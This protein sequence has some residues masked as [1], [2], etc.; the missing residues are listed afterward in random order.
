MGRKVATLVLVVLCWTM[1]TAQVTYLNRPDLLD[2]VESCLQN[3]Y[4][5]SFQKARLIQ[6]ELARETPNHPMPY[7]LEA[8]IVYWENFPLS[9]EDQASEKFV[10]QMNRT[11]E[12]AERYIEGDKT[13]LEGVFFDLYGRAFKAMFWADNGRAGKVIPD[14]RS[15]FRDTKEGFELKEKFNEFYFSTGLYNY[16][17]EAYPEAHPVYKP[18]LAFMQKG[19]KKLGLQQLNYAINH[20][21]FLKVE[22][23]LFMSIIQLKYEKDLNSAAIFAERL[24]R[25][26][27]KN[28]FYHGHLVTILLHQ[29]RYQ[30]AE[31]ILEAMETQEDDYSKMVMIMANAFMAEKVA[32]NDR[33]AGKGYL[34]TIEMADSFGPFADQFKAIGYMGLSRLNEQ[35]GLHSEA[36][37]YARKASSYT[38]YRYILDE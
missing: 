35:K 30:R 10:E 8:L 28:I 18:L 12:M 11:I 29:H 25:E 24:F 5:F 27:P 7:F 2:R 22:S 36:K 20:T 14:L 26:Y 15:M 21:V 33:L 6:R 32:G 19:D 1:T 34:K 31:E 9:P 3:T 38:T 37:R 16:Y 13:H 4:N 23:I 17:I